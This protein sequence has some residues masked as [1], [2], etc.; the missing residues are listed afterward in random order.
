M[1]IYIIGMPGCGKSK[2]AKYLQ[3]EKNQYII[4]LD[5]YIEEQLETD[6]PTIFSKY[7]EEYFRLLETRALE[8]ISDDF[9]DVI[10]SCGGGV[11]TNSNNLSVMKKGVTV[12][13][14]AP[15]E[16]LKEHLSN[17]STQRPLLKVKTIEQIYNE[18][19]ELYKK[20]ADVTISYNSYIEAADKIMEII[21]GK[22]KKKILVINGPNLNMLGLRDPKHYGTLTLDEINNMIQEETAFDFEFFQSNH[23]GAIVDK[24]QEYKKYDGIIINPAAYTHT[25]VAI[26]DALEIVDIVKV[27]VHLSKVDSREEFRKINFIRD[28]VDETFQGDEALSY[29][30]AV[31]YLKNKLNV[32]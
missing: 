11:V 15:I 2:T 27:E 3:I 17:S 23:E 20:F 31:R 8:Q 14:D 7:G 4:D 28:V 5:K 24:I 12:F 16:T 9:G 21:N 13:L 18:R 1:I 30:K 10:V 29:I 22:L 6:I 26:H 25:S 32:I 19:I